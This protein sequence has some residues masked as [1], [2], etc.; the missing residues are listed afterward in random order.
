MNEIRIKGLTLLG[1][2]LAITIGIIAFANFMFGEGQWHFVILMG[3]PIHVQFNVIIV[4]SGRFPG[5]GSSPQMNE[6]YVIAS[7]DPQLFNDA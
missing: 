2:G 5:L 7:L 1:I 6:S 3:S 4:R